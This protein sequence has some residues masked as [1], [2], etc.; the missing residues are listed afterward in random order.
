MLFIKNYYT[1]GTRSVTHLEV[2]F[3][4][5]DVARR[6]AGRQ[7]EETNQPYLRNEAAAGDPAQLWVP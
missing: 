5:Q 1:E 2:T 3:A 4:F 7:S 6:Q